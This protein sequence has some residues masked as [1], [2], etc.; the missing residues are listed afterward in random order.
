MAR[1]TLNTGVTP[2]D[3]LGDTL[4]NGAQKINENFVEVYTNVTNL[5]SDLTVAQ[6]EIVDIAN[7]ITTLATTSYVDAEI[8]QVSNTISNL[9]DNDNQ[10]LSFTNGQ[11]SIS[12]GN[13][14]DLNSLTPDLTPYATLNDLNAGLAATSNSILNEVEPGL[15]PQSLAFDSNTSILTITGGNFV[16]LS[17]LAGGGGTSNGSANAV[18]YDQS[19]NTTDDVIFNKVN[20]GPLGLTG[21]ELTATVNENNATAIDLNIATGSSGGVTGDMFIRATD[22]NGIAGNNFNIEAVNV[23]NILTDTNGTGQQWQFGDQGEL[24]FPDG[25]T[26]TTAYTDTITQSAS[27]VGFNSNSAFTTEIS[28]FQSYT[29]FH[30]VSIVGDDFGGPDTTITS[31]ILLG[32][33]DL[34]FEAETVGSSAIIMNNTTSG[35]LQISGGNGNPVDGERDGGNVVIFAGAVA[36]GGE[37]GNVIINSNSGDIFIGPLG[38]TNHIRMGGGPGYAGGIPTTFYGSVDFNIQTITGLGAIAPT[39]VNTSTVT[40]TTTVTAQSFVSTAS[41]TPT[42][43]SATDI[44]LDPVNRVRI[45]QAPIMFGKFTTTERDALVAQA[46]DVIFN[47]TDSKFQGFDGTNWVNF[48]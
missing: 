6:V 18:A 34:R 33:L 28:Q 38:N 12:G 25:T 22:V 40:A 11:L 30:K 4:R 20:V 42:L 27:V 23:V 31:D 47:T 36:S 14:V 48:H 1:Q 44:V 9:I 24:V 29:K 17:S 41:G 15:Q 2:N 16:D 8:A 37:G 35:D 10:S 19:L 26:Q 32:Q 7:T 39:S 21:P 45:D 5:R 13:S 3:G 43:T 46:G